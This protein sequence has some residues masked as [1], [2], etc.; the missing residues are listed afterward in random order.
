MDIVLFSIM[1]FVIGIL[2]PEAHAGH[3][4][5]SVGFNYNRSNYDTESY[6]WSKRWG[7]NLA[8]HFNDFSSVEA[9]FQDV[10]E[11]NKILGYEDTTFHDRI[12]SL[13]WNQSL[14]PKEFPIQPFFKAGVGQLNREATGHYAN[15][16]S[17]AKRVDSV[18]G[19]LGA[20]LRIYVTQRFAIRT[21]VTSYLKGGNISKWQDNLAFTIGGSFYF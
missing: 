12:Y 11:R 15:G 6:T 9:G 13:T 2:T 7:L 5:S 19:V 14:A 8:Y 3:F 4:E 16:A 21:E 1:A 17:P 18:T 20:G 10:I